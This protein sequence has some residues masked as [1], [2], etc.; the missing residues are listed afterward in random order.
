[1]TEGAAHPNGRDPNGRFAAGNAGGPGGARKRAFALR[2]AAEDAITEEH[3]QAMVRKATR[4]ALEGN[5]SAMRFVFDRVC[6]K[7]SEAVRDPEPLQIALPPL[8]TT[9]DCDLA[10]ERLI[11]SI[12]QGDLTREDAKLMLEAVQTRLRTIEAQELEERL[13]ELEQAMQHTRRR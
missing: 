5:L 1:M 9:T 2:H 11:Q 13:A 6:G 7:A 8:R 3:L 10:T 4:M 12:V